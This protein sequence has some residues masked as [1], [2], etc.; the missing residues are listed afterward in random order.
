LLGNDRGEHTQLVN[1]G[2]RRV[3]GFG[4]MVPLSPSRDKIGLP[5]RFAP[6]PCSRWVV[7]L[8]FSASGTGG[9]VYDC[10]AFCARRNARD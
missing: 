10:R 1:I 2:F 8:P 3:D 6:L 5:F 4:H 7:P 9:T